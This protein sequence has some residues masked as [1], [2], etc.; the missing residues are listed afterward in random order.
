[1]GQTTNQDPDQLTL[2]DVENNTA[3]NSL[4][5][6]VG[7]SRSAVINQL[8]QILRM[9][10]FAGNP[11]EIVRN[12]SPTQ[13]PGG[14]LV[15]Q[16][17]WDDAWADAQSVLTSN[18]IDSIIVS[19]LSV[20][21]SEAAEIRN[22]IHELFNKDIII[23]LVNDMIQIDPSSDYVCVMLRTLD[24]LDSAGIKLHRATERRDILDHINSID[25][26]GGRPPFGFEV[27]DGELAPVEYFDE[28]CA[29]L[30]LVDAEKLS[31]RTAAKKLGCSE[32]TI[33]RVIEDPERREWY[34]LT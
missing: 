32:R 5:I 2:A 27:V 6:A 18:D 7:A 24:L 28:I 16:F 11:S 25:Y 22:R 1:M 9:E 31:R 26:N 17:D 13:C 3:T 30:D 20:F 23:L 21:G 33:Q 29:T 34:G 4:G 10:Q 19:D 8:S 12:Q 14:Y 15:H